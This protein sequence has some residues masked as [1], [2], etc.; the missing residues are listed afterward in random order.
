MSHHGSIWAR[1]PRGRIKEAERAISRGW[2][3][4]EWTKAKIQIMTRLQ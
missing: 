3:I 1:N 4:V 2:G